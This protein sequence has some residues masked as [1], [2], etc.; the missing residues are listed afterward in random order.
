MRTLPGEVEE[1]AKALD[2]VEKLIDDGIAI[3]RVKNGKAEV[4]RAWVKKGE[5]PKYCYM[6]H[7]DVVAGR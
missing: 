3:E 6:V 2:Y 4:L 7:M 1:N 5:T